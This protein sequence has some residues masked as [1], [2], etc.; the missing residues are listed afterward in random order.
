MGIDEYLF[1]LDWNLLKILLVMTE[2][3]N[4]KRA[5]RRLQI[6]QPAVSRSISKLRE[7]LNDPLFV[8]TQYG[9]VLTPRAEEI[10]QRLP[11]VINEL[12]TLIFQNDNFDIRSHNGA[13]KIVIIDCLAERIGGGLFT[14]FFRNAPNTQLHL[15]GW[16]ADTAEQ[17]VSGEIDAAISY[18][19]LD[20][21]KQLVQRKL[22]EDEIIIIGR[23]EHPIKSAGVTLESIARY[24]LAHQ[25]IPHWYEEMM[26]MD[27]M[28]K[29]GCQAR[30]MFRSQY[31][32]ALYQVI[33]ESDTLFCSPKITESLISEDL[34]VFELPAPL[35]FNRLPFGLTFH[36]KNTH[37]PLFNWVEMKIRELIQ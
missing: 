16:G 18:F 6:S 12:R 21:S 15:L 9:F 7:Y 10:E 19:P 5:A 25:I 23:K 1:Q 33:R 30:I 26:L 20:V 17:L 13:F 34:E 22:W 36:G 27:Y 24:P 28:A 2:E 11:A 3:K 14:E 8:R 4:A 29:Q 35:S 37:N 31:L 32:M